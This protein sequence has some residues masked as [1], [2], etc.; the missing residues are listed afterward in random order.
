M[1]QKP[2]A[3]RRM[4]PASLD[5]PIR[6]L[7]LSQ[8]LQELLAETGAVTIRDVLSQFTGITEPRNR[9]LDLTGDLE[10]IARLSDAQKTELWNALQTAAR[11]KDLL[12]YVDMAASAT[13]GVWQRSLLQDALPVLR[14]HPDVEV[15]LRSESRS[16]PL[17][18]FLDLDSLKSWDEYSP[19]DQKFLS[20]IISWLCSG[21]PIERTAMLSVP[22]D[23]MWPLGSLLYHHHFNKEYALRYILT[24]FPDYTLEQIEPDLE[25]MLLHAGVT[26]FGM[27]AYEEALDVLG[28]LIDYEYDDNYIYGDESS[29]PEWYYSA[30]EE[31]YPRQMATWKDPDDEFFSPWVHAVL[32]AVLDDR[33]EDLDGDEYYWITIPTDDSAYHFEAS[34]KKITINEILS[35]RAELM[36]MFRR[37]A[38]RKAIMDGNPHGSRFSWGLVGSAHPEDPN[39]RTPIFLLD[40][41]WKVQSL[42]FK[43]SCAYSFQDLGDLLWPE[44]EEWRQ[45]VISLLGECTLYQLRAYMHFLDIRKYIFPNTPQGSNRNELLETLRLGI[46]E[47]IYPQSRSTQRSETYPTEMLAGWKATRR[48]LYGFQNVEGYE[49]TKEHL[50][51]LKA[52]ILYHLQFSAIAGLLEERGIT[53]IPDVQKWFHDACAVLAPIITSDMR[54]ASAGRN[55]SRRAQ[56]AAAEQLNRLFGYPDFDEDDDDDYDDDEDY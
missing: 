4:W 13:S 47:E 20:S 27:L 40:L 33:P 19:D 10:P 42:I 7:M 34:R 41:D 30:M 54:E 48:L 5:T 22:G 35:L 25:V 51:I 37:P 56:E 15:S 53:D 31:L 46:L 9:S 39:V 8:P 23:A 11:E 38:I 45:V 18:S 3:L 17:S 16:G 49:P 36:R 21:I 28:I 52:R 44:D 2:K 32:K 24:V 26:A 1:A 14:S 55:S 6:K 12:D 29:D 50:F 43:I